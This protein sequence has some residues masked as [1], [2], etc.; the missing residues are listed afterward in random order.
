MPTLPTQQHFMF[1][2]FTRTEAKYKVWAGC[3]FGGRK[4][5]E[6]SN[7]IRWENSPFS[8]NL[9]GNGTML[10]KE[11]EINTEWYICNTCIIN[12]KNQSFLVLSSFTLGWS[13]SALLLSFFTQT[14]T[15]KRHQV[16]IHLV[17]PISTAVKPA[18]LQNSPEA[19]KETINWSLIRTS[20]SSHIAA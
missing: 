10:F 12:D 18:G 11:Y 1:W 20:A 19:Q 17:S 5:C 13:L 3:N 16:S 9:A 14:M 7:Y 2:C 6:Y 15:V 4:S 8:I